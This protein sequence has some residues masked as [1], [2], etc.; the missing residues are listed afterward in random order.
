MKDARLP[1]PAD[2]VVGEAEDGAVVAVGGG[3]E[4][5]HRP[6]TVAHV[7]GLEKKGYERDDAY[8]RVWKVTR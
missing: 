3:G 7:V 2:L 1:L 6:R 8:G 5:Q 4:R